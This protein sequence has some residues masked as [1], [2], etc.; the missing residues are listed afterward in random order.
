MQLNSEN[1]QITLDHAN[2][3]V[4]GKN[5][6]PLLTLVTTGLQCTILRPW[7]LHELI[8]PQRCHNNYPW[9]HSSEAFSLLHHSNTVNQKSPPTDFP[10]PPPATGH[11]HSSLNS[12][13]WYW[14]SSTAHKGPDRLTSPHLA[15]SET[16]AEQ[17]RFVQ[18]HPG[19][20]QIS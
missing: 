4:R 6:S 9:Q 5:S 8:D 17:K 15:K 19:D 2:N 10:S 14:T 11:K 20:K 13:Y 18:G 3:A 12:S 1:S 7:L 16:W